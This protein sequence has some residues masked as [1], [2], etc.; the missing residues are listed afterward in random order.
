MNY[1]TVLYKTR[2]FLLG[3]FKIVAYIQVAERQHEI[4][5]LVGFAVR[6]I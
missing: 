4:N 2:S 6:S 1:K 3:R 5:R